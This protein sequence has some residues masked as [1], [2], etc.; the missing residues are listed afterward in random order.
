V[1]ANPGAGGHR[2]GRLLSCFDTVHWYS[3]DHNGTDPWDIFFDDTVTGK[4][5]SAYHYDRTLDT[6]AVPLVGERILKWWN[7]E[8]YDEF[9]QSRW[10]AEMGKISL[11]KNKL[12]HWVLHDSPADLHARFPNAKIISLIDTD[13]DSVTDRY[14][15]TTAEFPCA[16]NHFN[17]K[18]CYKNQYA[19]CVEKL[20]S[21]TEQQFWLYNNRNSSLV[22][23][24]A[25]VKNCLT[26]MNNVRQSYKH[27]N[28]L[29]TTWD[30][31]DINA[32]RSFLN[33]TT[34]DQQYTALI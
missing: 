17:L 16:V 8:D 34:I 27:E 13:L 1:L 4:S 24:Y 30:C 6:G 23:Y 32:L 31:L 12:T 28:Y 9:Y 19:E 26:V 11:P 3:S 25:H 15:Q 22:D 18:P 14:M 33:A 5:I 10:V 21:P 29:C 2:L 20:G 7:P